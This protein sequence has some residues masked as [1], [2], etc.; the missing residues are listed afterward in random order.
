MMPIGCPTGIE[1]KLPWDTIQIT[2]VFPGTFQSIIFNL[3]SNQK[4][5]C[6][7]LF[8]AAATTSTRHQTLIIQAARIPMSARTTRLR[9]RHPQSYQIGTACR[10]MM[11]R[12]N[13]ARYPLPPIMVESI[14]RHCLLSNMPNTQTPS[15]LFMPFHLLRKN[16]RPTIRLWCRLRHLLPDKAICIWF[17]FLPPFHLSLKLVREDRFSFVCQSHLPHHQI[18][19]FSLIP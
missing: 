13:T 10:R 11:G 8:T 14:R 16:F 1:F 15:Q 5:W 3:S 2:V 12:I 9:H 4:R 7:V 17:L 18:N 19:K 6:R